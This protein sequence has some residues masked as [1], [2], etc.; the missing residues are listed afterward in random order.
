MAFKQKTDICLEMAA[1]D[2]PLGSPL[3]LV[4]PTRIF[5]P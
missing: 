1:F 5:T 4:A 2:E 3:E